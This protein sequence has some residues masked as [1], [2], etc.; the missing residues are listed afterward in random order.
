MRDFAHCYELR[1]AG[2]GSWHP[3]QILIPAIKNARDLGRLHGCNLECS[4]GWDLILA[5]E[6]TAV[7]Y[8]RGQ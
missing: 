7:A 8:Q 3:M 2:L 1:S 5:G 6:F 4:V